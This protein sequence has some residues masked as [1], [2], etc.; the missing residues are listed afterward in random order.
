MRRLVF[1]VVLA[2]VAMWLAQGW[3]TQCA[4]EDQRAAWQLVASF[5]GGSL[6]RV[7]ELP[8]LY[9][10]GSYLQMGRQ[11]GRLASEMLHGVLAYLEELAAQRGQTNEQLNRAAQ[12]IIA[13]YPPKLLEMQQGMAETSGL[14]LDQVR[15]T[16]LAELYPVYGSSEGGCSGIAAWGPYTVDG[17]LVMGRNYDLV[18]FNASRLYPYLGIVMTNPTDGGQPLANVTYFGVVYAQTLLG[19][20]HV[21]LELNNGANS[22]PRGVAGRTPSLVQTFSFMEKSANL[23]ELDTLLR[24]N[25]SSSGYLINVAGVDQ[26]HSYEWAT[27]GTRRRDEDRSGLL[28]ATNHFVDP[29]WDLPEQRGSAAYVDSQQRRANLLALAEQMKGRLTADE[30]RKLMEVS[31]LAGGATFPPPD[32]TTYQVVVDP[33]RLDLWLRIPSVRDWTLVNL[34]RLWN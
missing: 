1:R 26:A 17:S 16:N 9:L 31:R 29:G 22:E 10:E 23:T 34:G 2:L 4:A 30:M 32:G 12:E 19:K 13:L 3:Q 33:A 18:N 28:V 15:I 21:F 25:P 5:E 27:T 20:N 24:G 14:T 8:V 6:Y 11:Y 7:Q